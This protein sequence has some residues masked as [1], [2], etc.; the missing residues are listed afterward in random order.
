MKKF[1]VLLFILLKGISAFAHV[2]QLFFLEGKL[3]GKPIAMRI[4]REDDFYRG[5]YFFLAEKKNILFRG[6]CKEKDCLLSV[7]KLNNITLKEELL[8]SFQIKENAD[9]SWSG[10]WQKGGTSSSVLLTPI[11]VSKIPHKYKDVPYVNTLDPLSY[12]RTSNLVFSLVK[13]QKINNITLEWLK[14]SFSG[15]EFIRIRKGL[16]ANEMEV[17]NRSLANIHINN[18]EGFFWCNTAFKSAPYEFNSRIE[19][20]NKNILNIT[21]TLSSNCHAT[22]LETQSDNL[23][24]D[25]KTGKTLS[26]ENLFYAGKDS[27][28]SVNS[29]EWFSYRYTIFGNL[30]YTKLKALYPDK[31]VNSADKCNFNKVESWQFPQW[32]LSAKGILVKPYFPDYL[33]CERNVEFL[34]P[35]KTMETYRK[36][37]F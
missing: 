11:D 30:I 5:E 28:P 17:V 18:V 29:G 1:Y 16:P 35:Y 10:T 15:V 8:E 4:V 27:I 7:S 24:I 21:T 34:I 25:I 32:R 31:F 2:E 14:E 37:V 22:T 26:L 36:K 33:H 23:T 6:N 12:I 3:N 19:L 9:R 13:T 20:I